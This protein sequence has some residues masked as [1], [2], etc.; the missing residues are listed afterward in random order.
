[1]WQAAR[2]GRVGSGSLWVCCVTLDNWCTSGS[3]SLMYGSGVPH[4][5][6]VGEM[7]KG[8]R[9]AVR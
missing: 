1:M 3:F 2:E 6:D 4:R 9:K 7:E 5:G 8:R